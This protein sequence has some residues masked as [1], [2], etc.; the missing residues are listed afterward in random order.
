LRRR[1]AR[2]KGLIDMVAKRSN[3]GGPGVPPNDRS[4]I[5]IQLTLGA[6][7]VVFG[8][9]LL[10]IFKATN[11]FGSSSPDLTTI[12]GNVATGVLAIGAALLPAGAASAA[13]SRILASLPP[14][15]PKQAPVVT[16]I[17]ATPVQAGGMNVSGHILTSDEGFW[18]VQ[19]GSKS[20][21][22]QKTI[23][24]GPLSAKPSD[25]E[26]SISIAELT[27]GNFFRVG[28]TANT[29]Q[30]TYSK[31]VKALLSSCYP[32]P[33]TDHPVRRGRASPRTSSQIASASAPLSAPRR[34]LR[35][36]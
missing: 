2:R 29:G 4:I 28:F 23:V 18:F 24:G 21:D 1:T 31:E 16:G 19:Y 34:G 15:P 5:L 8:A 12:G 13:S 17:T 20:G 35:G 3:P 32:V 10:V 14:Q 26:I 7:L 30:A 25:Q 27:P 11:V 22:Y 33:H 6:S 9:M 36:R